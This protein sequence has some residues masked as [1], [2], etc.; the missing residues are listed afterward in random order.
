MRQQEAKSPGWLFALRAVVVPSLLALGL[1]ACGDAQDEPS[2]ADLPVVH[3]SQLRA[4]STVPVQGKG[5][6][7]FEGVYLPGVVACENGNA[8][9]EALKAQAIAARSFAIFKLQVEGAGSLRDSQADQVY[10]CGRTPSAEHRRAVSETAGQ[11]MVTGGKVNASFYVSGVMPSAASCIPSA[12]DR[13]RASSIDRGVEGYVTHNNTTGRGSSLGFIGN[14]H[15]QGCM[16]QNG[17][18]CLANAGRSAISILRFYYGAGLTLTTLP[19]GV[20]PPPSDAPGGGG[21]GGGSNPDPNNPTANDPG[22]CTSS[23]QAP[24]ILPRSSWG[25]AAPRGLRSTHTPNRITV[26][27]TVSPA[28]SNGPSSIKE[29][30]D[31]HFQRGWSDIGYHFLIDR[32][33]VIYEGNPENRIGAHVGDQNTGNLGISFIGNFETEQFPEVQKIAGARLIRHLATKHNIT[34][35]RSLVKGHGERASTACPGRNVN[36]DELVRLAEANTICAPNDPTQGGNGSSGGSPYTYETPEGEVVPNGLKGYR[37]LRMTHTG[38]SAEPFFIDTVYQLRGATRLYAKSASGGTNS[39]ASIGEGDV[40]ACSELNSKAT[41]LTGGAS[42]TYEFAEGTYNSRFFIS[43]FKTDPLPDARSC[44]HTFAARVKV[45]TSVDGQAWETI[46]EDMASNSGADIP[47]GAFEFMEPAGDTAP[48]AATFKMRAPAEIVKV[49]YFAEKFPL[50]TGED[51]GNNYQV[52]YRFD[53][54]GRRLISAWGYNAAGELVAKA[55]KYVTV[56]D[57]LSFVTPREGGTY[58][59]DLSFEVQAVGDEFAEVIYLVN[60][61]EIGRSSAKGSNFQITHRLDYGEHKVTARGVDSSGKKLDEQHVNI[62]ISDTASGLYF[63]SPKSGGSYRA[64]VNMLAEAS[65][66][67]ITRVDYKADDQHALGTS[68]NRAGQ[69]PNTYEFNQFGRRKLTAHGF[70]AEG[71]EVA[72]ATIFVTLTDGSGAV[73]GGSMDTPPGGGGSNPGGGSCSPNTTQADR[74]ASDA[75]AKSVPRSLGQCWKY[76]KQAMQR[77]GPVN[78]YA[79]GI[80][81]PCS[82]YNF[83]LSAYCFYRNA[84]ANPQELRSKY[85]MERIN[86]SPTQAPRGAVI[87]WDRGCNGFHATHGHVE[88]SQGDGTACSDYCGRIR[89]GGTSCSG[90]YMPINQMACTN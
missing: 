17:S 70:N 80:S 75:R 66:P 29:V 57:G 41:S 43:A 38:S 33:G 2:G 51:R 53:G 71:R 35:N 3:I 69:F 88:I 83:Q 15:N 50:G 12:A 42:I 6:V 25:A 11:V 65:D 5:N 32:S 52:D 77:V 1:A 86:V 73:P 37:Y 56:G 48:R 8:P 4:Q 19:G 81:G 14:P 23:E 44:P 89:A 82:A 49:E 90:V 45:E 85:K 13:S 21:T 84:N 58:K 63:I 20:A 47:S 59:P 46:S 39:G 62:T 34:I 10:S 16:S 9:F 40:T 87:S 68:S 22:S 72:T 76:V 79:V 26:H 27:H 18:A 7:D 30:Q 61:Q 24:T 54:V 60:G 74:L 55:Q 36:M 67:S 31:W 64:K 78:P 28:R